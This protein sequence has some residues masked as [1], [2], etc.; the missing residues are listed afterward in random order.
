MTSTIRV[1]GAV[2]A[3]ALLAACLG[4]GDMGPYDAASDPAAEPDAADED[5]E[6]DVVEEEPSEDPPED[7]PP[8]DCVPRQEPTGS[9]AHSAGSDCGSCHPPYWPSLTVGGTLYGEAAGTTF[10]S[11]ATIIIT[12]DAGTEVRLVSHVT[13]NFHTEQA[14]VFPAT[15]AVSRCPDSTGMPMPASHGSCNRCH[16][17]GTRVHL[18]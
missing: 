16:G 17:P 18:P 1:M 14:L 2:L 11:G 8:G 9:M 15:V 10:V 5:P 7:P 3:P 12:D 6:P 4:T 13:G